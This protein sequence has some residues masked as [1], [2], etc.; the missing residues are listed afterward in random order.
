MI[1]GA[2]TECATISSPNCLALSIA[3]NKV[4]G[5]GSGALPAA[6]AAPI[7]LCNLTWGCCEQAVRGA[8]RQESFVADASISDVFGTRASVCSHSQGSAF[9]PGPS[10]LGARRYYTE[11]QPWRKVGLSPGSL[12]NT[13]SIQVH[14]LQ[15]CFCGE[16][17]TTFPWPVDS[18]HRDQ[19][20][21]ALYS[22][23]SPASF[24]VSI[25]NAQQT[26]NN[27]TPW[28]GRGPITGGDGSVAPELV[29]QTDIR[30]VDS[31]QGLL[32]FLGHTKH[33][34]SMPR[35]TRQ[36]LSTPYPIPALHQNWRGTTKWTWLSSPGVDQCSLPIDHLPLWRQ[37]GPGGCQCCFGSPSD[38]LGSFY[39]DD[40]HD[41]P[42]FASLRMAFGTQPSLLL[43]NWSSRSLSRDE[44]R[45]SAS[46]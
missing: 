10:L 26:G 1:A 22:T 5:S 20:P 32:V 8:A 33:R 34:H 29:P 35:L 16:N 44:T 15:Q 9:P 24:V 23:R 7:A 41:W 13:V 17:P 37:Q 6:H 12:G 27:S 3:A 19:L 42:P 46:V 40:S 38:S 28:F 14:R 31:E 21:A 39:R 45:R 25:Q 4:Q 18:G 30:I 43:C 2:Y 36:I 11:G